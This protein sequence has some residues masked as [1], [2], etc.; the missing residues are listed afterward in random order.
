MESGNGHGVRTANRSNRRAGFWG[1]A[2]QHGRCQPRLVLGSTHAGPSSSRLRINCSLTGWTATNPNLARTLL[3]ALKPHLCLRVSAADGNFRQLLGR[4]RGRRYRRNFLDDS[5]GLWVG[6]FRDHSSP[7]DA[8]CRSSRSHQTAQAHDCVGVFV[9]HGS[10]KRRE[11]L[12]R[13]KTGCPVLLLIHGL[14]SI[15]RSEGRTRSTPP[16]LGAGGLAT[17][18]AKLVR[19]DAAHMGCIDSKSESC[20]KPNQ[21]DS[22]AFSYG[23]H[24]FD[25]R[26]ETCFWS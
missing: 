23:T 18:D 20:K 11:E 4:T 14:K 19:G 1:V 9:A 25:C 26:R 12:G 8:R 21:L 5:R 7:M 6:R 10:A 16:A 2:L 3:V 17:R 22:E 15:T 13:P 24:R